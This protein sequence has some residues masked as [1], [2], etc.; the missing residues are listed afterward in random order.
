VLGD[1]LRA[2]ITVRNV[3]PHQTVTVIDVTL[4]AGCVLLPAHGISPSASPSGIGWIVER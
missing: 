1:A 3:T 2:L 4:T